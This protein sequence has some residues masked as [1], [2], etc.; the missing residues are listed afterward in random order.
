[1][2]IQSQPVN[3]CT[4]AVPGCSAS[5]HAPSL[6]GKFLPFWYNKLTKWRFADLLV[7]V[8]PDVW[9]YIW[10]ACARFWVTNADTWGKYGELF[11]HLCRWGWQGLFRVCIQSCAGCVQNQ[12]PSDDWGKW[13]TEER[14]EILKSNSNKNPGFLKG[15]FCLVGKTHADQITAA[16]ELSCSSTLCVCILNKKHDSLVGKG[17]IIWKWMLFLLRFY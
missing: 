3:F 13:K 8:L 17:L 5:P 7:Y 6:S 16:A 15:C 1:M 14:K 11:I 10:N 2:H 12:R 9:S 4:C